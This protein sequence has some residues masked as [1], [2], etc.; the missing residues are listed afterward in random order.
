MSNSGQGELPDSGAAAET[1][2][3]ARIDRAVA[4]ARANLFWEAIWPLTAPFVSLA[5]LFA[6]L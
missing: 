6:A 3:R 2:A 4:R 5:A 1:T